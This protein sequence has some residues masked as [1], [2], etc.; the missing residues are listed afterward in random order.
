MLSMFICTY[1]YKFIHVWIDPHIIIYINIFKGYKNIGS[2]FTV[3]KAVNSF[4]SMKSFTLYGTD[5]NKK[6]Y[7]FQSF[8][9][10]DVPANQMVCDVY[11]Y[12]CMDVCE[13]VCVNVCIYMR[14]YVYI[15]VYIHI[16][17]YK[18]IYIYIYT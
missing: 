6:K 4:Q 15:Y 12:V 14:M 2:T 7:G 1:V 13:C 3:N 10:M 16:C 5:E 9:G 11:V 17:I 18:H 8:A